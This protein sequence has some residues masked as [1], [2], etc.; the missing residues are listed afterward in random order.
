MQTQLN[1]DSRL[2]ES[3]LGYGSIPLPV[4]DVSDRVACFAARFLLR[5]RLSRRSA[6]VS[7]LKPEPVER[8]V[9]FTFRSLVITLLRH[10]TS[11][12]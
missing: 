9:D 7:R 5:S 1:K 11:R 2:G 8:S 4:Y 6:E 3:S 10:A 12:S